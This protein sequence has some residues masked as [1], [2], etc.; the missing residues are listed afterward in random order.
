[1]EDTFQIPYFHRNTMSEFSSVISGGID[2]TKIPEPMIGMSALNNTLSPH[3]LSAS[4]VEHAM[5]KQ[6]HPERVPDDTMAF[7]VE[8]WL[9][10]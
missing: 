8:S 1:M 6:L 5:K 2:L 10:F 9:V 3:G 7:V 4:E